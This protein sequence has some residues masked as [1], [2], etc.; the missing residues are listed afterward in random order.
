MLGPQIDLAS[1]PRWSRVYGTFG[2]NTDLVT[3]MTAAFVES[4]QTDPESTGAD[5][6]WGTGSVNAMIKHFPGDGAG[7]GGRESHYDIGKYAVFP[8]DSFDEH[9]A[10]F[11]GALDSAA[12]MTS[13][14]I[15]LDGD[16]E[17]MFSDE[18]GTAYVKDII[19]ILREDHGY[20]G[21]LV[22]D[23]AITKGG[24]GDPEAP[25]GTAWGVDELTRANAASRS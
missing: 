23:W 13:Y 16:G 18:R 19:D 21:V 8:G 10:P 17:P 22:T 4:Y 11:L 15:T 20:D 24:A 5:E 6:G 14:S 1:D 9:L 7:E 25:Y 2:E 3:E 12:I